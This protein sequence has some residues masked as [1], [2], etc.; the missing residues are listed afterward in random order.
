MA[1]QKHFKHRPHKKTA[2]RA[3][4]HPSG[5]NGYTYSFEFRSVNG[6]TGSGNRHHLAGIH[7]LLESQILLQP[8][9]FQEVLICL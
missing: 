2:V 4:P 6:D 1:P 9:V 5:G 7:R 8:K 3:T